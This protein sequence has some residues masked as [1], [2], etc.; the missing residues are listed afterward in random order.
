MLRLF[1]SS[2]P[3]YPR[4][5]RYGRTIL[6]VNPITDRQLSKRRKRKCIGTRSDGGGRRGAC[7]PS[8]SGMGQSDCGQVVGEVEGVVQGVNKR[9]ARID[10]SIFVFLV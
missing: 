3:S 7:V 1:P 6:R 8:R 10:L 2:T 5:T 4:L 9:R